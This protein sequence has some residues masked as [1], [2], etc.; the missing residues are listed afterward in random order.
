MRRRNMLKDIQTLVLDGLAV[1][2]DLVTEII[3]TESFNVRILSIRDVQHLNQRKLQQAL[4]YAIRSS[5]PEGTPKLQGL[6]IFGPKDTPLVSTCKKDVFK[7]PP[8][9]APIDT[10]PSYRGIMSSLGAQIGSEWNKKSQ[11]AMDEEATRQSDLW[12]GKSGN[13]FPKPA[14][15]DWSSTMQSCLGL[16]SFDAVLCSGPRHAIG[17]SSAWYSQPDSH[18]S[19]QI[20]TIALEGCS[21]CGSAPEG[22]AK[23]ASSSMDR[24]PL[25]APVPIHSSTT[26]AAKRPPHGEFEKKLLVRCIECLKSRYCESCHKWWCEDCYQAPGQSLEPTSLESSF[27]AEKSATVK[28][29]MDLCV[30][31]CLVGEMMSGAGS[32]GMWG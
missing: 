24:L 9:I 16:I 29:L 28:V 7:Y 13:I 30:D 21:G 22:L 1:P 15:T 10:V 20:G 18:V 17:D 8:G 14:L 3:T 27:P 26:K 5:R 6:Y 25:L 11:E 2:A 31:D 19:P 32:N 12:F 4:L 23:F